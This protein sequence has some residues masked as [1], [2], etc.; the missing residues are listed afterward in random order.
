MSRLIVLF[1]LIGLLGCGPGKPALTEISGTITFKGEPI[2]AGD[3]SFTPD[4]SISNG[5]LRMYMVKDGKFNSEETPESGLLPGKYKV[6]VN[7]YDGVQIPNFYSGKQI[8]NAVEMEMDIAP[9]EKVAKDVV[10]PE[11]AGQNVR[12]IPTADF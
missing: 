3:I 4:V 11:S 7:G 12:H 8:F 2:P 5:E 6:R 9:G 1:F 10:I